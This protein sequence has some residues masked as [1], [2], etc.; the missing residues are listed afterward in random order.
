MTGLNFRQKMVVLAMDLLLLIELGY[1]IY[2]GQQPG[3]DLTLV[4]L[5]YFVP[6]LIL[7]VAAARYL[8]RRWHREPLP[9]VSDAA[10]TPSTPPLVPVS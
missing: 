8:I 3:A 2:C 4:F 6:S 5:K 7:T 9:A 1:S 10:S